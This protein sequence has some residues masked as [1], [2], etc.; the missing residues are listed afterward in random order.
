MRNLLL[1][2]LALAVLLVYGACQSSRNPTDQKKSDAK[3]SM[4]KEG[5]TN[6]DFFGGGKTKKMEMVAGKTDTIFISVHQIDSVRIILKAPQDSANIRIGQLFTP[7]GFAD[8]PYG[9][10]L[11]YKFKEIGQYR[12]TVNEN[13]MV[14]NR[15]S[16]PYEV[17]IEPIVR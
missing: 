3:H 12:I 5:Y 17:S 4:V 16:G 2:F 7:N 6:I 10:E 1:F 9:R 11:T 14:G 15:Y 13:K 8:G